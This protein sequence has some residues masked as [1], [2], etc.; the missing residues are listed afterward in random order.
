MDGKTADRHEDWPGGEEGNHDCTLPRTESEREVRAGAAPFL[1][2]LFMRILGIESSCDETSASVVCDGTV[3]LSNVVS[4]ASSRYETLAGVIP[5]DAA[6]RQM[7]CVIPVIDAA[8][9]EAKVGHEE[10]D[11]IALTYGP[12]L[13]G[14]LLVGTVTARM[15]SLAFDL[16]IIPVHHTFGHLSSV[17]PGTKSPGPLFPCLTLSVSGG[18]S[19]LWLRTSHSQGELLGRTRDDAVGEA[20]DKGAS[21]LGLPYPGG[22]SI[23][24][25]AE[26]GSIDA[27][28]F[29]A[30]L[31]GDDTL[32]FSFSGL[33]TALRYLL[34]DEKLTPPLPAQVLMNVAASYQHALCSHLVDRVVR[35]LN[36]YSE[37][38]EVHV[39]GGVSSSTHLRTLLSERVNA[40]PVRWP[41]AFA[42]CTDNAAM[43][44][45]AAYFLFREQPSVLAQPFETLATATLGNVLRPIEGRAKSQ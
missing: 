45:S 28:R 35:A 42:Y 22:P 1:Y 29:P 30:P 13:M 7:E 18:H 25:A 27:Y 8:L 40:L 37:V 41:S 39:V 24:K 11:V 34:R 12:G 9:R 5:E 4:S 19:D 31:H 17:W 21:M 6:R 15:I 2:R 23:A 10:I 44:A 43:I 33:K 16:P 36:R 20:F 3:V 14:S 32:D 26:G 38:R